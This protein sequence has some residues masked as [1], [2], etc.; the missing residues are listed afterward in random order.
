MGYISIMPVNNRA[1]NHRTFQPSGGRIHPKQLSKLVEEAAAKV[2]P[3]PQPRPIF[4]TDAGRLRGID[5]LGGVTISPNSDTL[6]IGTGAG[7]ANQGD[8]AVA[9][10]DNSGNTNQG[11]GAV[12]IGS[13]SG[14]KNQESATVSVGTNAGSTHQKS[15]SVAMGWC[16]GESEQGCM[17]VAVGSKAGREN[18]GDGAISVGTISGY[19]SQGDFAVAM[20][21]AAGFI[22]Q[23]QYAVSLGNRAG[24]DMQ[25]VGSVSVGHQAG[26]EHQ[27]KFAVAI[28]QS[29]GQTNQGEY[30]VSI[31]FQAGSDGQSA[32]SIVINATG[33]PL[34]ASKPGLYVSPINSTSDISTGIMLYDKATSEITYDDTGKTFVIQHPTDESKYLVH[35]CVEGP[36][37]GVYYRGS[38]TIESKETSV[39]VSLPTYVDKFASDF[40]VQL[41]P[42]WNGSNRLLSSSLVSDNK[43]TVHGEPGDFFWTV[44]GKRNGVQ[45]EVDK[46]EFVLKGD[47]PYKYL[48]KRE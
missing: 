1:S 48:A 8:F 30:A 34:S 45:A 10:G 6:K 42:V 25:G 26:E 21:V 4:H 17:S 38:S 14:F 15:G 22:D 37:Q 47:G 46:D 5:R 41:T 19:K 7:I 32:N 27:G 31:G 35:A 12:S 2:K 39:E 44:Y 24:Y 36:E 40:T 43:F 18:Q 33:T 9:I 29:S 20:G 16:S 13:Y 23:H 28:G 3:P 11:Q